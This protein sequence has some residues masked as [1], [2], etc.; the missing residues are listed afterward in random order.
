MR[1]LSAGKLKPYN[2]WTVRLRWLKDFERQKFLQDEGYT[3]LKF[4]EG[5]VI[6]RIDEVVA[7]ID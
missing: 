7:E 4:S 5:R 6:Y 1:F 3:V 2:K